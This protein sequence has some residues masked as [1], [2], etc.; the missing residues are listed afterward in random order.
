[1]KKQLY[2]F[3]FLWHASS[4]MADFLEIKS[5]EDVEPTYQTVTNF[6]EAYPQ[7]ALQVL[8]HMEQRQVLSKADWD[9]VYEKLKEKNEPL[10][11]LLTK[12]VRDAV[13]LHEHVKY[14]LE[15]LDDKDNKIKVINLFKDD[16]DSSHD[17]EPEKLYITLVNDLRI[18][19]TLINHYLYYQTNI[20]KK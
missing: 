11:A 19:K 17:L 4:A 14:S 5:L 7:E 2:T 20:Y 18:I 6:C 16:L 12:S 8:T 1:M 15:Y 13:V 10:V 9:C 3:L